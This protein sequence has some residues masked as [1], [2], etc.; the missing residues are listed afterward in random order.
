[1]D[2]TGNMFSYELSTFPSSLFEPSGMP[3]EANKPTLG[4]CIWNM[5]D[6]SCISLPSACL[7]VL[8]GGSL[9]QRLPWLK[10]AT[11]ESICQSYVDY[12]TKRYQNVVV[13]FDG[14]PNCPTTKDVT[15]M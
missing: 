14:N 11:F 9:L 12:V 6:C 5:G 1:M 2:D 8:D 13:V 15:H 3:R 10:N 7:F 4:D